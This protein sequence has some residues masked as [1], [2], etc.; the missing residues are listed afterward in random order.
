LR[1][2]ESCPLFLATSAL[3]FPQPFGSSQLVFADATTPDSLSASYYSS[4]WVGVKVDALGQ[5]EADTFLLRQIATQRATSS[6][7]SSLGSSLRSC[8]RHQTQPRFPD[9]D[10]NKALA[11]HPNA[12]DV[13]FG[14]LKRKHITRISRQNSY[15]LAHL[16]RCGAWVC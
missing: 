11:D 8:V 4:C 9:R 13:Q 7:F 10:G 16:L 3:T 15:G 5:V 12:D 2:S 1:G 6:R 14:S